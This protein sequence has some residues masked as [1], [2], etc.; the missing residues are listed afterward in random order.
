MENQICPSCGYSFRTKTK[1][2]FSKE[3]TLLFDQFDR[4]LRRKIKDVMALIDKVNPINQYTVWNFL[5]EIVNV[6]VPVISRAID[7]FVIKNAMDKGLN[8]LKGMIINLNNN[9]N[10]L[11]LLYGSK[12]PE[13]ELSK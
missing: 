2:N 3:I 8:Y 4:P 12:P 9:K 11:R 10:Q 1:I 5:K 7:E 6:E 13:V